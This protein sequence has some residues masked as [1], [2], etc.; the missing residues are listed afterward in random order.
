M[1]R[2]G[3]ISHCF[4]CK[5][6]SLLN[7]F[8]N[9]LKFNQLPNQFMFARPNTTC[10]VCKTMCF[11]SNAS[12]TVSNT[13]CTVCKTMCFVSNTSC[14]VS[15]TT[16]T[17]STTMCFVSNTTCLLDITSCGDYFNWSDMIH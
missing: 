7:A 17:V 16:C 1:K 6:V 4:F 5:K 13:S 12:Y 8:Y 11:V 2:N 10:T 9:M 3:V 15:N 14:T